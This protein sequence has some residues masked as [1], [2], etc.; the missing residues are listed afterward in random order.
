M[1]RGATL[2]IGCRGVVTEPSAL[3]A[4]AVG[5]LR[6]ADNAVSSRDGLIEPRPGFQR[7]ATLVTATTPGASYTPRAILPYDGEMIALSWD[8]SGAWD[9]RYLEAGDDITG[10]VTPPDYSFCDPHGV[11]ARG[12]FYL[13]TSSGMQKLTANDDT[14]FGVV[15]KEVVGVDGTR[16]ALTHNSPTGI[17]GNTAVAYRA[18]I[19]SEDE[20]G[21]IIKSAPSGYV[22]QYNPDGVALVSSFTLRVRLSDSVEAG[23]YVE[24]YR[25][26]GIVGDN[27]TALFPSDEMFL[28]GTALLVSA[29]I[30]AGYVD[31]L[32]ATN[33][34]DL[35]EAL[36]TNSGVEGILRANT[37]PPVAKDV[38]NFKG[39][40]WYFNTTTRYQQ[41]LILKSVEGWLATVG[42]SLLYDPAG[43][44]AQAFIADTTNLSAVL[45]IS[46]GTDVEWDLLKVGQR[47]TNMSGVV[48]AKV[49]SWNEGGATITLDVA[50]TAT[51][52]NVNGR[53]VD[54]IQI[55]SGGEIY[56]AHN[57][58]DVDQGW[59]DSSTRI[60]EASLSL[61]EAING[62]YETTG[63][64]ATYLSAAGGSQGVILLDKPAAETDANISVTVAGEDPW[65]S[66]TDFESKR[67]ENP[68]RAYYSKWQLPEAVPITSFIDF[69]DKQSAILRGIALENA[70]LVFTTKGIYRITGGASTNEELWTKE[71]VTETAHLLSAEAVC[72]LDNA[73]YA[74]T[75]RGLI[76]VNE[77]DWQLLSSPV[78][79]DQLRT[80]EQEFLP[81]N[82]TAR[83]QVF[84]VASPQRK[85]VFLS[86]GPTTA[87]VY[88]W[89][90]SPESKAFTR[91]NM[92]EGAYCA[93]YNP[94]HGLLYLGRYRTAN[95]EVR[96]EREGSLSATVCKDDTHA[97][98]IATVTADHIT[99]SAAD[100]WEPRIGDVVTQGAV[101]SVVT[102]VT[103]SDIYLPT[104]GLTAAAATAT[105]GLPMVLEWQPHFLGSPSN[106]VHNREMSFNFSGVD[107]DG[108]SIPVLVGGINHISGTASFA[109]AAT[110]AEAGPHQP[111]R[112]FVPRE[113]SRA[114]CLLPALSVYETGYYFALG[115]IAVLYDSASERSDR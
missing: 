83:T 47:I 46:P 103:G 25:S 82:D 11:E 109:P 64:R 100:Q 75:N 3:K 84:M 16:A 51:A 81:G 93:A 104:T 78:I 90:F 42:D 58:F 105:E 111:I 88:W 28:A 10:T 36:Y 7:D 71:T 98:T 72:V 102:A 9:V 20:S 67:D 21:Y 85:L 79:G 101:R 30:T 99:V 14:A 54:W 77:Y 70:L 73:C 40:T 97:I 12:N 95:W 32:D 6:R 112:S 15:G 63:I 17:P 68:N 59:T 86:P 27:S 53:I 33:D 35:G 57:D 69:G 91:W 37:P 24:L 89:A 113:I 18:L 50:A 34:E 55:G 8:G 115:S 74:W 66:D 106:L 44:S 56:E 22:R 92:R 94:A 62:D 60:A 80:Q 41:I 2:H 76:V 1:A 52:S 13:C 65:Q 5:A 43:L 114:T 107:L 96:V 49:V 39:C 38:C 61:V 23:D 29:D 110:L 87:P 26:R 4:G 45:S 48:G 31:I 108:T 19:R